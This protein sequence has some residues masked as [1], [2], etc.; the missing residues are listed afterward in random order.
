MECI[1]EQYFVSAEPNISVAEAEH[2][3]IKYLTKRAFDPMDPDAGTILKELLTR[4]Y[5]PLKPTQQTIHF[6]FAPGSTPTEQVSQ[7]LEATSRGE[8]P[9]DIATSLAATIKSAVDIE[10]MTDIKE[11]L[12]RLEALLAQNAEED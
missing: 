10:A 9:P 11:R 12:Q 8:I 7:I 6:S 1:R 2:G 5:P 3:F 4:A